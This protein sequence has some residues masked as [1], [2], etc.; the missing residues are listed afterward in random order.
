MLQLV[1]VEYPVNYIF[2]A[3]AAVYDM[4]AYI[5]VIWWAVMVGCDMAVM[6]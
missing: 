2:G 6:V 1:S 5:I 3:A 4:A